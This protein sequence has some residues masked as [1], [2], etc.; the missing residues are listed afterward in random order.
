MEA[1]L[2]SF[3]DVAV[4][5]TSVDFQNERAP[6]KV[7]TDLDGGRDVT[8]GWAP[9]S[10]VAIV[11][12]VVNLG[13]L[14]QLFDGGTDRRMGQLE[15]YIQKIEDEGEIGA[16][17]FRVTQQAFYKLGGIGRAFVGSLS[18]QNITW[19]ARRA[20]LSGL[21]YLQWDMKNA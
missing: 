1:Y 11:S 12:A 4:F 21:G 15:A 6:E 18:L 19:E 9:R 14:R 7:A 20:A 13:A 8:A 2:V 10:L 17:G 16:N 5:G 3:G